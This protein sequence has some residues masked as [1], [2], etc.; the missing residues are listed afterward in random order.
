MSL[1]LGL[2]N[3]DMVDHWRRQLFGQSPSEVQ[4]SALQQTQSAIDPIAQQIRDFG[5]FGTV[6]P[7]NIPRFDP[8][9]APVLPSA[10][11]PSQMGSLFGQTA[12]LA[13]QTLGQ[14]ERFDV[15]GRAAELAGQLGS[16]AQPGEQAAASQLASRLFSQGR[17]G[18]T[19]GRTQFAELAEAQERAGT[20]RDIQALQQAQ[21]EQEVLFGR[22]LGLGQFASG[23]RGQEAGI[24]QALAALQLQQRGQEA[25]IQGQLS[26]LDLARRAQDIGIQEALF[27]GLQSAAQLQAAPFLFSQQQARPDQ[28]L[29]SML[30]QGARAVSDVGKTAAGF[31]TGFS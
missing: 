5:G 26:Q 16:L 30:S 6:S 7:A 19:G 22:G 20:L 10:A 1:L 24:E 13:G 11:T 9:G 4:E 3:Q 27:G 18:T 15:G 31:M 12:G 23:L 2:V 28:G 17:L 8:T 25:G 14:A 21:A 29:F